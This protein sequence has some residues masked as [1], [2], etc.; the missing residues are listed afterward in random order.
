MI[1][2]S[3]RH[4]LHGYIEHTTDST[5][6]GNGSPRDN[7]L[8]NRRPAT[9]HKPIPSGNTNAKHEPARYGWVG[10]GVHEGVT[11]RRSVPYAQYA[12]VSLLSNK[13]CLLLA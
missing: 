6:E 4:L 8:Y 11:S 10:N 13:V 5:R 1:A 3:V 2:C 12:R 7:E 9:R